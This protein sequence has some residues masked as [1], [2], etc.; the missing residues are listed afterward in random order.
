MASVSLPASGLQRWF[1]DRGRLLD[2]HADVAG[3]LVGQEVGDPDEPTAARALG[4]HLH[5]GVVMA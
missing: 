5:R 3:D 2:H 1:H 4:E